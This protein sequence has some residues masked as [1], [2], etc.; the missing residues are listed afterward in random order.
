MMESIIS[1]DI[2]VVMKNKV[3]CMSTGKHLSK[4]YDGN[5]YVCESTF[6]YSLLFYTKF[7]LFPS[8]NIT[9]KHN[10]RVIISG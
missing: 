1:N 3:K 5:I 9:L 2:N 7:P 6:H 8:N 10:I 4:I